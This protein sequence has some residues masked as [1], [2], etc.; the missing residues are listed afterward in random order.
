MSTFATGSFAR[1][2]P[3]AAQVSNNL[4]SSRIPA[5]EAPER[6]FGEHFDASSHSAVIKLMMLTFGPHPTD[7][8]NDVRGN[9]EGYEALRI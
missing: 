5:F 4:E 7:L 6:R 1:S 9:R 2:N 8:F 3:L